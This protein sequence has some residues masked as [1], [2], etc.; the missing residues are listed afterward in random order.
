MA[1]YT[2]NFATA[3]LVDKL[4]IHKLAQGEMEN[5]NPQL[6][7]RFYVKGAEFFIELALIKKESRSRLFSSTR[8]VEF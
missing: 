3:V 4:V 1:L 7:L 8:D 5:L 2:A 6:E